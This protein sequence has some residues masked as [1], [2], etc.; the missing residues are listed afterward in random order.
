M[1]SKL[2]L[3]FRDSVISECPLDQEETTIGRKPENTV[4]IDNLAVSGRHARVLKIGSKAI[5]EDLGST[6]GTLVN[7]KQITKHVLEHGDTI[8]IGKHTLTYV[9]IE[10]SPVQT[11][12]E[13]EGEMDKTMVLTPQARAAMLP[14]TETPSAK[15]MV[16]PLAGVQVISGPLKGRSFDLSASL[17][18]IGKGDSCKI[19]VKGFTVGKQAAVITRRPT[20]YHIAHLEGMA[21]PKVNGETVG[22][23]PR[24]LKDGDV[25][26]IGD[27]RMEFFIKEQ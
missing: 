17:T 19:K 25:I 18:S 1:A 2:I 23:E 5:I 20:G 26:E 14:K 12:A 4:H 21:K 16:M 9:D 24:T 27:A 8:L 6:N 7:D 13:P 22:D 11:D 10:D 3:K 15:G